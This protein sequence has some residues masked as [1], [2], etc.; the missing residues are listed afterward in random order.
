MNVSDNLTPSEQ[1]EILRAAWPEECEL[2]SEGQL[3]RIVA[4]EVT[5]TRPEKGMNFD[6]IPIVQLI[7]AGVSLLAAFT[8]YREKVAAKRNKSSEEDVTA[9]ISMFAES[10]KQRS[11][12]DH[13]TIEL[14]ARQYVRVR[15]FQGR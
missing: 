3:K 12:L 14:L 6:V 15:P 11:E 2:F 8:S 4:E 13:A 5:V 10:A 9:L 7:T 1:I